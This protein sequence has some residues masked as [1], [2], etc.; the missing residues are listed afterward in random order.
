MTSKE[1]GKGVNVMFCP[2]CAREGKQVEMEETEIVGQPDKIGFL[3]PVDHTHW[4]VMER[5]QAPDEP[6]QR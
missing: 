5:G 4:E 6:S 3:C 1:N 2:S